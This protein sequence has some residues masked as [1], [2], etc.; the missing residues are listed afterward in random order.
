LQSQKIPTFYSKLPPV[1]HAAYV[2]FKD[3]R[4][5]L[6]QIF[7][8][9]KNRPPPEGREAKAYM[10]N[11]FTEGFCHFLGTIKIWIKKRHFFFS[12]ISCG[13]FLSH[14]ILLENIYI[15][16]PQNMIEFCSKKNSLICI[17]SLSH[18]NDKNV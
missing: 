16:C 11:G 5:V 6:R 18:A 7:A 1:G 9:K 2:R 14:E 17:L 12:N 4:R 15:F 13:K 3:M 10:R 8:I